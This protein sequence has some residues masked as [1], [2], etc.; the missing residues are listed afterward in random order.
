MLHLFTLNQCGWRHGRTN[1]VVDEWLET[2]EE[3]QSVPAVLLKAEAID[4]QVWNGAAYRG[5]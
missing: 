4:S 1:G 5:T 2:D 3:L